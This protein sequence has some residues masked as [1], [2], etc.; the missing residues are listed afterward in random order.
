M[1]D[2]HV[3]NDRAVTNINLR[4]IA[5]PLDSTSKRRANRNDLNP[6]VAAV[7]L[8]KIHT[9]SSI[10]VAAP[11]LTLAP[12]EF[13]ARVRNAAEIF[14]DVLQKC[15]FAAEKVGSATATHRDTSELRDA[16]VGHRGSVWSDLCELIDRSKIV[17]L[18]K[19]SSRKFTMVQN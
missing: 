8:S 14:F 10:S 11:S 5:Q 16:I 18:K 3:T 4:V 9:T 6:S 13:R 1:A 17:S 19:V 2:L 15:M 7:R 12:E